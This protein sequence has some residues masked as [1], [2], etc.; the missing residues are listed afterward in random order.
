M[1]LEQARER[2]AVPGGHPAHELAILGLPLV[3]CSPEKAISPGGRTSKRPRSSPSRRRRPREAGIICTALISQKPGRSSFR[4]DPPPGVRAGR[5][6]VAAGRA[7]APS[8]GR[9]RAASPRRAGGPAARRPRPACRDSSPPPAPAAG[10]RRGRTPARRRSRR[11]TASSA[12]A[13]REK[14]SFAP[15]ALLPWRARSGAD[16]L[17]PL[18]FQI[19]LEL[20]AR[21]APP[22]SGCCRRRSCTAPAAGK[23]IEAG[24]LRV[25]HARDRRL[26][27]G[28]HR[29]EALHQARIARDRDRPG[30]PARPA[31]ARPRAGPGAG[32][33]VEG[34]IQK[35]CARS[36]GAQR[37]Q[38]AQRSPARLDE[39]AMPH[40]S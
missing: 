27:R 31:A 19:G 3:H 13:Q 36:A 5:Q 40:H 9:R 1:D 24:R 22:E 11:P 32:V 7:G 26:A 17:Q 34:S 15:A 37:A 8:P 16:R 21:R 35:L 10:R 39:S 18:L 38:T 6:L 30:A 29:Q 28:P 12:L 25:R 23:A 2:R 14:T 4:T 20:G 33:K